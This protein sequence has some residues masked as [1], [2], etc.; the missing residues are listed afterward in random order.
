VAVAEHCAGLTSLDVRYCTNLTD[1]TVVAVAEHCAGLTSL[2]INDCPKLTLPSAISRTDAPAILRYYRQLAAA[3]LKSKTAKAVTMG[4]GMAGKTS[5]IKT[6]ATLG[7]PPSSA[8][9]ASSSSSS[10]SSSSFD[11]DSPPSSSPSGSRTRSN[12]RRHGERRRRGWGGILSIFSRINRELDI[13]RKRHIGG[14]AARRTRTSARIH[15]KRAR[16]GA[17]SRSSRNGCE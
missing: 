14:S 6:L 15:G 5:T 17:G 7:G 2:K 16:H 3:A 8:P 11:S 12:R 10:S 9:P 13:Q 4:H 1:A